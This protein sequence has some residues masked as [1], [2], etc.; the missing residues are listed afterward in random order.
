[1]TKMVTKHRLRGMVCDAG[2]GVKLKMK[3]M[4]SS[5]MAARVRVSAVLFVTSHATKMQAMAAM[6]DEAK[7]N[8]A[9]NSRKGENQKN[10]DRKKKDS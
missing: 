2:A 5:M 3:Y 8:Q 4:T 7:G 6:E 9:R 1:M 10:K